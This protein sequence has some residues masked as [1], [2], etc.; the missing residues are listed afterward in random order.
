MEVSMLTPAV[1]RRSKIDWRA[2]IVVTSIALCLAAWRDYHFLFQTPTATGIDGYYYDLQVQ[3]L[4]NYSHLFFPT[5]T[6]LVLLI[7]TA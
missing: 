6:P 1:A 4:R 7:A 5:H 2:A 3:T